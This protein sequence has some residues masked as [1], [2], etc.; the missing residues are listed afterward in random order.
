MGVSDVQQCVVDNTSTTYLPSG[1]ISA[2][3]TTRRLTSDALSSHPGIK[4][5]FKD[6]VFLQR[7]THETNNAHTQPGVV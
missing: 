2:N 7:G 5:S 3:H 1:I 4:I 6:Q